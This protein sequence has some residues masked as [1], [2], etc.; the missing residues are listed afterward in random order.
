M[1][2]QL[3]QRRLRELAA[4]FDER[5]TLGNIYQVD[6]TDRALTTALASIH[7]FKHRGFRALREGEDPIT[8][9]EEQRL[10]RARIDGFETRLRGCQTSLK[11]VNQAYENRWHGCTS[12]DLAAEVQ[13]ANLHLNEALRYMCQMIYEVSLE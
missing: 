1:W 13:D 11:N 9:A 6:V 12:K 8:R 2:A 4:T 3:D 5:R 10:I 7:M